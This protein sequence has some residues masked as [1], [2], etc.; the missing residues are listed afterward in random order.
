MQNT[1]FIIHQV[2]RHFWYVRVVSLKLEVIVPGARGSQVG[3]KSEQVWPRPAW[4]DP[5]TTFLPEQVCGW[6]LPRYPSAL[7]LLL[8]HHWDWQVFPHRGVLSAP[9]L[10]G[11]RVIC[12]ISCSVVLV[13]LWHRS[14]HLGKGLAPGP[15]QVFQSERA[16]RRLSPFA[17]PGPH[18]RAPPATK[19]SLSSPAAPDI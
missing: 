5:P 14:D 1:A 8:V 6:S 15:D 3:R 9:V 17:A 2:Q 4:P 10:S 18:L 7:A 12:H 16:R 13:D 11:C 19:L